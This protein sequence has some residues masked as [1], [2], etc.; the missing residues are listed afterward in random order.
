[1]KKKTRTA[2]GV[3][4][5]IAPFVLLLL[6]LVGYAVANYAISSSIEADSVAAAYEQVDVESCDGPLCKV[7]KEDVPTGLDLTADDVDQMMVNSTDGVDLRSSI[8]SM[9]NIVL[10]FLGIL[11]VLGIFVGG[12]VGVI[13]LTTGG[14]KGSS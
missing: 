12:L 10:G 1:M 3:T 14:K 4:C 13:L 6:V 8:G 5:I 9:L 2:L 7:A 11:A